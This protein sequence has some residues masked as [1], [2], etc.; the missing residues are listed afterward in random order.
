MPAAAVRSAVIP[1][2]PL[3]AHAPGK[4]AGGDGLLEAGLELRQR[5]GLHWGGAAFVDAGSVSESAVPG[6]GELAIGVGLGVRYFTPVGP[7][8]VDLATPLDPSSGDA[9]VQLY[10]GI[11]QAF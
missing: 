11:G 4:P 1:S 10:I 2:S 6:S 3:A 5:F 9:P 8:R 7:L